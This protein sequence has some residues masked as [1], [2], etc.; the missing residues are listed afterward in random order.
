VEK[1]LPPACAQQC[2]GRIR[3][4]GFLDDEEGQVYKLV[5]KYKV[6][7]PLRADYGT[8]PNVYYVPPT[9]APPKFDANGKIIE[10]SERVPMAELEK[11][12]GKEV[13]EA[14]KTLKAEMKKR[15][16]TG[17]SELMDLL[18]AYK[19]D[20]MF[21]LDNQYY[22]DFAKAK[23]LSAPT[24]VDERYLKGKFT[25]GMTFFAKAVHS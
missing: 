10:G 22:A 24:P 4:V 2:V 15:K 1:G 12:F 14:A 25:K 7:L 21:R 8:V 11:L 19:H 20:D 5:N 6:A 16:E 23:G 17:E 3:F 18:I 13:H 9:E